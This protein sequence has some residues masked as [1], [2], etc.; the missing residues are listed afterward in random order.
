MRRAGFLTKFIR[1]KK[2]FPIV[3]CSKVA[4]LK[5]NFGTRCHRFLG[6]YRSHVVPRLQM[7]II[8]Y[9]LSDIGEGIKEV[10]IKEWFIKEGD[11]VN[12]FDQICEVQSDKASVTITSR[13]DGIVRKLYYEVDETAQVGL[14]FVDIEVTEEE[15]TSSSLD[16]ITENISDSEGQ[17]LSDPFERQKT[18]VENESHGKVLATPVVRRM[19]SEM[20]IDLTTVFG[21]GPK[22][23]VLK[24]DLINFQNKEPKTAFIEV[25]CL[26]RSIKLRLEKKIIPNNQVDRDFFSV[27]L[28][29]FNF[30]I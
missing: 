14:P 3:S 15:D 28:S 10:V 16:S 19:A 25:S 24:E 18:P 22:G 7:S 13:Y 8:P 4:C 21:T 5:C 6:P 30:D 11:T 1:S 2:S 27:V 29:I 26:N 9:K 20:K 23:R 17:E 12:Q